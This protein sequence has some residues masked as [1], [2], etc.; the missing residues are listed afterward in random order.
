MDGVPK[1]PGSSSKSI[2]AFPHAESGITPVEGAEIEFRD[3]AMLEKE[4][5]DGA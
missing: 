1:N 2:V 4:D 5:P 3:D